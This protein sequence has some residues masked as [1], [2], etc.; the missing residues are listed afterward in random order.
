M[1][2]VIILPHI[3]ILGISMMVSNVLQ[4]WKSLSQVGFVSDFSCQIIILDVFKV[5]NYKVIL[6]KLD[7]SSHL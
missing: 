7:A 5:Q 6:A 3:V 4:T 2:M 1:V